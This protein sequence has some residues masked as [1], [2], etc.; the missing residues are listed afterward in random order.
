[1]NSKRSQFFLGVLIIITTIVFVVI[2]PPKQF[3]TELEIRRVY[4][5]KIELPDSLI[6]KNLKENLICTTQLG[7]YATMIIWYDSI[8]CSLCHLNII[9]KW[10]DFFDYNGFLKGF[11]P[12][13]LFT[14]SQDERKVFE[15]PLVIPDFDYPIYVDIE[16]SFAKINPQ[17]SRCKSQNV[18]LLDRNG[19][20]VLVGSPLSNK[21]MWNLYDNTIQTLITNKGLIQ[22]N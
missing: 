22:N 20:I 17:L 4:G 1:M 16:N 11:K 14:P 5:T 2:Y 8:R 19:A 9:E 12:I 13:I 10:Q 15:K 7:E 3:Q 18:F 6:V 21:D